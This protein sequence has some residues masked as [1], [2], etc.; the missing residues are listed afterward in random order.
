MFILFLCVCCLEGDFTFHSIKLL[1]FCLAHVFS[2]WK[3]KAMEVLQKYPSNSFTQHVVWKVEGSW[4]NWQKNVFSYLL[5]LSSLWIFVCILFFYLPTHV[6]KALDSVLRGIFFL[7]NIYVETSYFFVEIVLLC[8]F[9]FY[10]KRQNFRGRKY[11]RIVGKVYSCKKIFLA[12][13]V[14]FSVSFYRT[15]RKK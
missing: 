5:I 4:Q 3:K 2:L 1:H 9:H 6:D 10:F 13:K 15:I 7:T 11:S 12:F 8:F 14:F